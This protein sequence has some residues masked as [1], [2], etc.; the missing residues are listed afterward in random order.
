MKEIFG[1]SVMFENPKPVG[2]IEHI[3]DL[4]GGGGGGAL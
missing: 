3:I 4:G 2:L 1:N